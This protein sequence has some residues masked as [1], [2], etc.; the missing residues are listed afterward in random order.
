M[1]HTN[2]DSALGGVNDALADLLGLTD[3]RPL[4]PATVEGAAP[5][6]TGIGRVGELRSRPPW[7][8]CP[9]R[10]P[11]DFRPRRKGYESPATR[12]A[13]RTVA[14][15]GGSGD[16]LFAA[17]RASGADVYLTADLRHHP[18]SE[19]REHRVDGRP[20]LIDVAHWASEWPWLRRW[21]PL[22]E[23]LPGLG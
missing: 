9:R 18:A 23:H 20:Y 17:V 8:S 22:R 4:A 14:L 2:A 11:N 12:R 13:V 16:S 19:A 10:S 21:R 1:A 5:S 7:P 15:C 6:A 3:R